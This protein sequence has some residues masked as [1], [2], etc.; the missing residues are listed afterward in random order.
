MV[1]RLAEAFDMSR[2]VARPKANYLTTLDAICSVIRRNNGSVSK[3]TCWHAIF[4]RMASVI[5]QY[6]SDEDGRQ[7]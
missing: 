6:F 7:L 1:D 2:P 4:W 5:G 3:I